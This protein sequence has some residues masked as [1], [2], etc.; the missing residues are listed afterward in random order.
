[1]RPCFHGHSSGNSGLPCARLN[2]RGPSP[3][4]HC[5][6]LH[7][8]PTTAHR[9]PSSPS[10]PSSTLHEPVVVP[11]VL[12]CVLLHLAP[13]RLSDACCLAPVP[14]SCCMLPPHSPFHAP[15]PCSHP[16][17]PREADAQHFQTSTHARDPESCT[18]GSCLS[19]LPVAIRDIRAGAALASVEC[20]L[21]AAHAALSWAV[22][23]PHR[24]SAETRPVSF[25]GAFSAGLPAAE[26]DAFGGCGCTHRGTKEKGE[27]LVA[28][29]Y[30]STV[31]ASAS[32][33][34]LQV[35]ALLWSRKKSNEK[36]V[37]HQPRGS[38][39]NA[40]RFCSLRVGRVPKGKSGRP[41]D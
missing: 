12:H 7:H 1:M 19:T 18:P 8:L 36:A 14:V 35:A 23:P 28:C 27:T 33:G 15:I 21:M 41:A 25:T 2:S 6:L 30:W 13:P 38:S 20:L 32:C 24:S 11:V 4:A 10:S 29:R 31:S 39:M 34:A 37:V 9:S 3:A 16:M 40:R 17:V 26:D 22:A 5:F